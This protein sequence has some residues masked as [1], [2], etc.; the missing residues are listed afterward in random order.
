MTTNMLKLLL[1]AALLS[2]CSI[3][4]SRHATRIGVGLAV[5]STAC[6]WGQT[7]S[8]A[9][10]GWRTNYE[11]NPVMGPSPST[12]AV[13]AYMAGVVVTTLAATYLLPERVRPYLLGVV[14]A[15]EVYTIAGNLD[16]TSGLCGVS[17][18]SV[19]Q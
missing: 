13:D 5:A 1:L 8:A 15:A 7:R 10:A 16:T 9:S 4:T 6:D 19:R 17:G 12:H 2:A 11:A 3:S 14:T 18:G